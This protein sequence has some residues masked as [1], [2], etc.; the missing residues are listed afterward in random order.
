AP[1]LLAQRPMRPADFPQPSCTRQRTHLWELRKRRT[2]GPSFVR[3]MAFPSKALHQQI[4]R[5]KPYRQQARYGLALQKRFFGPAV[6]AVQRTVAH[7]LN[8][9]SRPIFLHQESPAQETRAERAAI[10]EKT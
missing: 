10:P 1:R 4:E 2:P 8:P 3:A 5:Q 9:H 6:F 7:A